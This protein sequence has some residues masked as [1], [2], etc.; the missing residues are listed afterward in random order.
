MGNRGLT[1]SMDSPE[2]CVNGPVGVDEP[3]LLGTEIVQQHDLVPAVREQ[4]SP[5]RSDPA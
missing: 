1:R 3:V 2:D 4:K 5:S